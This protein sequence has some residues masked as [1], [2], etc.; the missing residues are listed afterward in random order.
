MRK[1]QIQSKK[2]E[3]IIID[4]IYYNSHSIRIFF[5]N[6]YQDN[7]NENFEKY[8]KAGIYLSSEDREKSKII[9]KEN[10]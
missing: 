1:S 2:K 5:F 9:Y 8:I 6:Y 7:K 4:Y 3:T 10:Y